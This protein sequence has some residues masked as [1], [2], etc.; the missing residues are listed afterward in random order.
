MPAFPSYNE[1][2]IRVYHDMVKCA[3]EIKA[4]PEEVDINVRNATQSLKLLLSAFQNEVTPA[5]K[6]AVVKSIMRSIETLKESV[7]LAEIGA[8]PQTKKNIKQFF[9][10]SDEIRKAF[11]NVLK[12]PPAR[13]VED[14]AGVV[15]IKGVRKSVPTDLNKHLQKAGKCLTA[16]KKKNDSLESISELDFKQLTPVL[17]STT[18]VLANAVHKLEGKHL[19]NYN[20]KTIEKILA[21]V[22]SIKLSLKA[23]IEADAQRMQVNL[24]WNTLNEFQT[25]LQNLEKLKETRGKKVAPVDKEPL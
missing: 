15:K 25:L 21:Q 6:K 5:I 22:D 17:Q 2:A 4:H 7:V 19:P 9:K 12:K 16:L 11:D 3:D 23:R 20:R 1:E 18:V 14:E 24:F 13:H 10:I 8:K